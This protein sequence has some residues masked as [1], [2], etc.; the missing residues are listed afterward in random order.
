MR[1]HLYDQVFILLL[2][3]FLYPEMPHQNLW[4]SIIHGIS[5]TLIKSNRRTVFY[6]G[7]KS[8]LRLKKI[9]YYS[10]LA[11]AES[12]FRLR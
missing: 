11:E 4:F 3:L 8:V 10:S 5:G 7:Q 1:L 6:S 9:C 2:F 12:Q